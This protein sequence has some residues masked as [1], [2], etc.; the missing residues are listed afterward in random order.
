MRKIVFFFFVIAYAAVALVAAGC[1]GVMMEKLLTYF[2]PALM[3][4]GLERTRCERTFRF[5]SG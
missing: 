4:D 2:R 1:G 3:R 5:W